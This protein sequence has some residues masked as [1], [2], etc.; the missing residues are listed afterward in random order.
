MNKKKVVAMIACMTMAVS[1]VGCSSNSTSTTAAAAQTTAAAETTAEAAYEAGELG[2]T[3]TVGFDQDFPPM[4]FVGDDGQYTGF[5]LELAQEVAET[6]I[7]VEK[8]AVGK[9]QEQIPL[10]IPFLQVK[11]LGE[12]E[13]LSLFFIKYQK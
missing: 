6:L 12:M 13:K 1:M 5:D 7:K 10:R 3:L 11:Y 9:P 2:G 4:G 8:I